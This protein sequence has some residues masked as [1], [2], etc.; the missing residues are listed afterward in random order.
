MSD[1]AVTV[2]WVETNQRVLVAELALLEARLGGE[3]LVDATAAVERA[4]AELSAPA[5]IDWVAGLF[6]LTA[7]ERDLL[8]LCAGVEM[9]AGI[10]AR[11]AAA[12]ETSERPYVTF[13]L[14]MAAL[15]DPHWTALTP[16]GP[17]R[18]CRLV[19][20]DDERGLVAGRI[21]VDERILHFL[22]G[23]N[24]LDVRLQAFVPTLTGRRT[25]RR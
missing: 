10:A 7:F 3:S 19:A 18:R 21:R 6:G 4:R 25:S 14:A 23:I 8:L 12:Q 16:V 22:A 20:V 11:C 24:F 15:D 9:D 13:G 1:Q 17:L 5:A 2:P